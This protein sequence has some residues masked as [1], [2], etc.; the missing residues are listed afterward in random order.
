MVKVESDRRRRRKGVLH[1]GLGAKEMGR[2]SRWPPWCC[3]WDD[4]TY[5]YLQFV[6]CLKK[7]ALLLAFARA[8]AGRA[9]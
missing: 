8:F 3:L 9:G 7:K 1:S 4:H 5:M 2:G 6:L